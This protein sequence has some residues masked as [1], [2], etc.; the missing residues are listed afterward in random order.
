MTTNPNIVKIGLEGN[1]LPPEGQ[2]AIGPLVYDF[3]QR[4]SVDED[5]RA[6]MENLALMSFAMSVYID[7]GANPN[8]VRLVINQQIIVV[9]GFSQGWYPIISQRP[10][11]YTVSCAAGAGVSTLFFVNWHVP[12]FQWPTR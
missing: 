6:Q 4:S 2:R 5:F 10:L 7:S 11:R 9:Q 8:F 1:P 12:A 3:A